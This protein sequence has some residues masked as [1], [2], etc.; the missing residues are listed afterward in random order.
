MT[1]TSEGQLTDVETGITYDRKREVTRDVPDTFELGFNLQQPKGQSTFFATDAPGFKVRADELGKP[2]PKVLW[3]NQT[4]RF[5]TY[6]ERGNMRCGVKWSLTTS[7][8]NG[9]AVVQHPSP[10]HH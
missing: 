4:Q 2:A 7:I 9:Q 10:G 3:L 8:V 1:T 6:I 5:Y